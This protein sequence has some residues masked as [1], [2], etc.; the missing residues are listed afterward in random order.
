MT[1]FDFQKFSKNFENL[2]FSNFQSFFSE[3]LQMKFSL[4]IRI[5]NENMDYCNR[6]GTQIFLKNN[7]KNLIFNFFK[8]F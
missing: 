1:K 6:G 2:E 7:L 3:F 8:N 5:L 4:K